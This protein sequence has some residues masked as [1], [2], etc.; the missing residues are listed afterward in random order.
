MKRSLSQTLE[1]D[2]EDDYEVEQ[3]YYSRYLEIN[4]YLKNMNPPETVNDL[5]VWANNLQEL[6]TLNLKQYVDEYI[7]VYNYEY[8]EDPDPEE[9]QKYIA[10]Y[11]FDQKA[12]KLSRIKEPLKNLDE[13]IGM[14]SIKKS[15]VD[16]VLYNIQE[17]HQ[18]NK[19]YLHTVITGPPGCGKCLHPDTKVRLYS[20]ECIKAKHLK[21]GDVL[22]DDNSN[23]VTIKSTVAGWD[24]MYKI[25]QSYGMSYTVNS[26]HVL[27]LILVDDPFFNEEKL[28]VTYSDYYGIYTK[29]FPNET[30]AK[31][32]LK[33]VSKAGTR[34]D[35]PLQEY[36]RRSD[37]WKK[38][39][40]GFKVPVKLFDNLTIENRQNIVTQT[41]LGY[42]KVSL[43]KKEVKKLV[44]II[45]SLGLSCRTIKKGKTYQINIL[46]QMFS[47]ITVKEKPEGEYYGFELESGG[48]FLLKDFTVTHNTTVAQIIGDIYSGLGVV[49]NRDFT[50]LKRSD[51]IA[52]YLGQSAIKTQKALEKCLGGVVFIDEAYSLAPRDSEKDSFAKEV[53]DTLNQF[54]S[55]HKDDCIVIVAGYKSELEN[56][57]FAMNKG[58]ERRFP[59]R[60]H[61]DEYDVKDLT[62][63]FR[64]KV[65]ESGW[66]VGIHDEI[67]EN[68]F[69]KNKNYFKHFGGDI[70]TFLTK[71]RFAN[72]RRTFKLPEEKMIL[73]AED[74]ECAMKSHIEKYNLKENDR[75]PLGMYI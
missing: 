46:G 27:T 24:K 7:E 74:L 54:L 26:S 33:N 13:L 25:S 51:L 28:T 34:I 56:T 66:F 41:F 12:I 43:D 37:N 31:E 6:D 20:G 42:K 65:K 68:I 47:D 29:Y 39:Y 57:F 59:W 11:P 2:S 19:D 44:N 71:C 32:F 16:M 3:I 40:K 8:Y 52:G 62:N 15:V 5:I 55:E 35:I 30:S 49:N 22:I 67:L 38:I 60:F 21:V 17:F 61:I 1:D 18:K 75:P 70:E 63:I 45:N 10:D 73:S 48:R 14:K 69:E 36:L 58:L 53:I 72:V 9:I 4:E 23:P 50:I 64:L